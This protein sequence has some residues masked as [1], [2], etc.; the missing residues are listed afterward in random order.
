MPFNGVERSCA[1]ATGKGGV[2]KT[3]LSTTMTAKWAKAGHRILLVDC[4]AQATATNSLGLNPDEV[5]GGRRLLDAVMYGEP[6]TVEESPGRSGLDVVPAGINTRHLVTWLAA[7]R[8]ADARFAE[9]F[10]SIAERYDR[11]VF[12]CPPS[13]VGSR[14]AEAVLASAQYVISPCTDQIADINGLEALGD[15]MHVV[16]SQAIIAGVVLVRVPSN[17]TKARRFAYDEIAQVLGSADELFEATVRSAPLAWR[18][19][20]EA[21]MLPGEFQATVESIRVDIKA[22]IAGKQIAPARNL[23]ALAD[24]LDAVALEAWA[25]LSAADRA[26]ERLGAYE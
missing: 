7:Q 3:M 2:G 23:K 26:M 1:V 11:L 20:Q 4:D 22:R 9:T 19:S 16:E 25:R 13:V 10:R 14:L 18:Q 5:G 15:M 12:D 6:L 8:D 17:A 24:D 21:G